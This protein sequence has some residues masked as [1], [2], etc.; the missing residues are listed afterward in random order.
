MSDEPSQTP[1]AAA[2][3]LL[4]ETLPRLVA[5]EAALLK[6]ASRPPATAKP[7]LDDLRGKVDTYRDGMLAL[8]AFPVASGRVIDLTGTKLPGAR[9]VAQ[10]VAELL[11]EHNIP[12]RK[13]ALQTIAKG[14]PN[15]MGR[16]REAWNKLLAWASKQ[17]NVE[18]VRR[19][20]LYL[21]AG[22]AETARSLPALP[23]IDTA[24]LTFP[25]MAGLLD[26][27][28]ST[29][30]G[31][32][33]EQFVIAALL[34]AYVEQLGIRKNE[35]VVTKSLNAAD[36][37]A[38]AAGDVQ[39]VA[40]G[41]VLEAYEVTANDWRTKVA[42]AIEALRHYDLPRVHIVGA[43]RDVAAQELADAL[44]EP[45]LDVSV[46]DIRHEVR[47]LTHR[48]LKPARRSAIERLYD[49]LVFRQ[50]REDLVALL[51]DALTRRGLVEPQA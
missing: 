13:D 10:A 6:E 15:Y 49:H 7:W 2:R 8:L 4:E 1:A 47:S 50:P 30:S 28:L 41:Q 36:A 51:V 19:A 43:A 32:A 11:A 23:P 45:T 48:L 22:V 44:P 33:Y 40:G 26:E 25:A 14:S 12:G 35:R 5:G 18:Q 21:L 9:G 27:L 34:H 16:D 29:P 39:H 17:R 37:S 42:Q 3:E 38:K 24:R 20:W 31:G 46:L